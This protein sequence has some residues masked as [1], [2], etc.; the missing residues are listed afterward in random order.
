TL[1]PFASASL[2]MTV[3]IDTGTPRGTVISN[4]AAGRADQLDPNLDNN[5]STALT[6]VT[7]FF[8]GDVI[9]SEFRF[10]GPTPIGSPVPSG[11]VQANVPAAA[12]DDEFIEIY[13]NTDSDITVTDQHDFQSDST[14]F[15]CVRP[16]AEGSG[17]AV[18][19]SDNPSV[20]KFVIPSGT[21]IPAR[22]HYLGVNSSGYSLNGYPAGVG[23]TAFGDNFYNGD[24]PDN[25]GIALFR[26]N[27]PQFFNLANRLDAVGFS[28]VEDSLFREGTG[29]T[30]PVTTNVEHSFV[31]DLIAVVPRDTDNNAA[32]FILVSTFG[33]TASLPTAQLGAPGPENLS[34]P[35]QVNALIRPSLIEPQQLSSNPPNNVRTGSG[36]GGT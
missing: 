12:N 19:S 34:A 30:N 5:S 6:A 31:R 18:V 33:Q 16:A 22:G 25:G 24:I 28:S 1:A 3:S 9:I 32:D 7:G 11:K 35:I 27:N 29:L 36:N 26:T 17:W 20:S 8:A 10:R 23:T 15:R 14:C 21:V 4:T 2:S 13:N